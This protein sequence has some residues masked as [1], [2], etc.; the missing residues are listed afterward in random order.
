MLK[1]TDHGPDYALYGNDSQWPLNEWTH[2]AMSYD[3]AVVPRDRV[4]AGA[5]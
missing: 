3:G 1:K 2:V 4:R 5:E